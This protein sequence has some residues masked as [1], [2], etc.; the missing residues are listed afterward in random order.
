MF[1][2]R[3]DQALAL[4]TISG[5]NHQLSRLNGDSSSLNYEYRRVRVDMQYMLVRGVELGVR[6]ESDKICG[7]D[8]GTADF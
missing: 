2:T 4:Q 7:F 1:P 8:C 3:D 5:V 6:Y